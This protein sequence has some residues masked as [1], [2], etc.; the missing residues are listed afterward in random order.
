MLAKSLTTVLWIALLLVPVSAGAVASPRSSQ[1]QYRLELGIPAGGELLDDTVHV[2]DVN[3]ALGRSFCLKVTA[4]GNEALV[5][6]TGDYSAESGGAQELLTVQTLFGLGWSEVLTW[7][8]STTGTTRITIRS[9]ARGAPVGPYRL[10]LE[11]M[12]EGT[13]QDRQ[14]LVAELLLTQSAALHTRAS[15]VLVDEPRDRG[16]AL[17]RAVAG[18][19]KALRH[20]RE[21]GRWQAELRGLMY[22]ARISQALDKPARSA[23]ILAASLPLASAPEEA[24]MRA[25]LLDRLGF[26]HLRQ[27]DLERARRSLEQARDLWQQQGQGRGEVSTLISLCLVD[28]RQ[29]KW[30][31]ARRCYEE[32]LPALHAGG[33]ARHEAKVHIS[34]GGVY[35]NLGEPD[36]A[37]DSYGRALALSERLEDPVAEAQT[38]NNIGALHRAMGA[39]EEGIAHYRQAL[40]FFRRQG[41]DYWQGRTL[42]NLGYAY[43][44]LGDSERAR[45]F[46]QESLVLRRRVG[47]HRGEAVTLRNLGRVAAQQGQLVEA[48]A[49]HRETLDIDRA[50]GNLRGQATA[51]RLLG[52]V[53]HG[54]KEFDAARRH[55]DQALEIRRDLG[56]RPGIAVVL[57]ARGET[58]LKMGEAEAAKASFEEALELYR[59]VRDPVG[60][61]ETRYGLARVERHS[62]RLTEARHHLEA[63]LTLVETLRVRIADPSQQASFLAARRGAFELLID[64]L[65]DLHHR[66]P[67]AGYQK[68]ALGVS[69]RS[70]A[71]TL[72]DLLEE[73]AADLDRGIAPELRE[74]LGAARRRLDAKAQRQLR[75]LAQQADPAEASAVESEVHGALTELEAVRAEIR[76][77]S[78]R[79]EALSR[80]ETLDAD[81]VQ[82]LLDSETVLLEIALGEER[83]FLFKVTSHAVASFELPGRAAMEG[84]ARRAHQQLTQLD[85]RTRHT[86]REAAHEL[87]RQILAPV[88]GQLTGRRLVVVPDGALHYVP[89]ATLPLPVDGGDEEVLLLDRWEV[90]HLPSASALASQRRLL[91]T[92]EPAPKAAAILADPV[93]DG[94]DPRLGSPPRDLIQASSRAETPGVA[95]LERLPW[96]GEEALAIAALAPEG[97]VLTLLGFDASRDRVLNAELA[98]YRILHFATHGLVNP[99]HLELSGLMLSQVDAEGRTRDGFLRLY[100]LLGLELRAD[101]VVLSGCRTALGKEVRG[102]GF[103]GLARGFLYAGVPQVVASLWQV[104]DQ[105]TAELMTHFYR[106]LL[107]DGKPAATA[108]R[109]AQL[110][111]RA[112]RRWQ[113]PFF[114]GAFLFQ[115]GW[116]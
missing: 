84:L 42:N 107:E 60:E 53:L 18:I 46:F 58:Q 5:T 78:P 104:Q 50:T 15:L 40:D 94:F 57:L 80:S 12:A 25:L 95:G 20:G 38:R 91:A 37:I 31:A 24:S 98:D 41:D 64:V 66:D 32:L 81:A 22:L 74:R 110:A 61:T 92:R 101:L 103:V 97:Q 79:F 69:E 36:L 45:A 35:T 34:L 7:T 86:P 99:R 28:L 30:N 105:A 87:A 102:E 70:R 2:Y 71:R 6:V 33:E 14:T 56:D 73:P 39:P 27:G 111:I 90:L 44:T 100:D 115:G 82:G 83:S 3:L 93:F 88:A 51:L 89:F 11:P 113:D 85:L 43:L 54:Q 1:E 63:A 76:R 4:S 62:G 8:N 49:A 29:G 16:E 106:G 109:E 114:W 17:E 19:E 23:E 68:A 77:A 108:L 65:M 13:P 116:S 26:A 75:V 55:L 48:A 96:S 112:Q 59:A 9:G 52:T 72:L 47:D 21:S 67:T 10:V